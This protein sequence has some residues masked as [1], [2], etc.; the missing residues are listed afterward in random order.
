MTPHLRWAARL[1]F[2]PCY[3]ALE[4][5]KSSATVAFDI[6]TPGSRMAAGFVELPLRC[7][8]DLEITL[9][10][11]LISLTPGTVTVAVRAEPATLWVH[12]M[13]A[14]DPDTLRAE[15]RAMETRLLSAIRPSGEAGS[16]PADGHGESGAR[17]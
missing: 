3:Y 16:V 8:T 11:N 9:I 12:G 14:P 17:P 1:L 6:L 4:V 2:F 15:L 13:Y 7:T 5:L 10:A